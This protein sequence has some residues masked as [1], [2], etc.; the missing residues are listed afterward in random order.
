MYTCFA[1]VHKKTIHVCLF[2]KY[3]RT[4]GEGHENTESLHWEGWKITLPA[5]GDR[6]SSS[7]MISKIPSMD[8]HADMVM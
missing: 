8:C 5:T 3:Y 7:W 1:Y 4:V 2:H 6:G